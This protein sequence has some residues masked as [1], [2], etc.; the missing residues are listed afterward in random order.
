MT[1]H[2]GLHQRPERA[3]W[4]R[5]GGAASGHGGSTP[6]AP[7]AAASLGYSDLVYFVENVSVESAGAFCD[8]LGSR[9]TGDKIQLDFTR[10]YSDGSSKDFFA[11][12][13]LQ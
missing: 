6:A 12:V 11:D 2:A 4:P 10:T 8:V 5:A 9:K 3:S 1:S 7:A 13:T